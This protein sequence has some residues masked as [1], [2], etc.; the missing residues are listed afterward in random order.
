LTIDLSGLDAAAQ[1]VR[2]AGGPPDLSPSM[3]PASW[4][5]V[6]EGLSGRVV[7]LVQAWNSLRDGIVQDLDGLAAGLERVGATFQEADRQTAACV[8]APQTGRSDL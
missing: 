6:H 1:A 4:A 3:V 2:A 5:V 7:A 8:P